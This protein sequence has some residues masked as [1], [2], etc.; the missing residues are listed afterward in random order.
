MIYEVLIHS[1]QKPPIQAAVKSK[2]KK[3]LRQAHPILIEYIQ[4][5]YV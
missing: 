5:E 1:H 3:A 2:S 4:L